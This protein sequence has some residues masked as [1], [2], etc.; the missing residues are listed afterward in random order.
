MN[1]LTDHSHR[2][3]SISFTLMV[4][5]MASIEKLSA[6]ES[7]HRVLVLNS[8]HQGLPWTRGFTDGINKAAEES[9]IHWQLYYE[10]LD[11]TRTSSFNASYYLEYLE[12]RYK[13]LR[14]DGIIAE[15]EPAVEFLVRNKHRIH[16]TS[17]VYYSERD[18]VDSKGYVVGPGQS[19]FTEKTLE[20]AIAQNPGRNQI[21]FIE[22]GIPPRESKEAQLRAK[23]QKFPGY[24][25]TQRKDFFMDDLLEEVTQYPDDT[26]IIYNLVFEDKSGV[27]LAPRKV[28]EKI[29]RAAKVPVYA[30]YSTFLDSGIVGGH[31]SDANTA[32]RSALTALND[33]IQLGQYSD[34]YPVTGT[35][36][37]A[38]VAARYGIETVGL[39]PD[40]RIVNKPKSWW[41]LNISY[42]LWAFVAAILLTFLGL[43]WAA[44]LRVMNNRLTELNNRL[45]EAQQ[46]L[47]ETNID[48]KKQSTIDPLTGL[49]N[50]R[51]MVP[52]LKQ[53]IYECKRYE[54]VSSLLLMDL[55]NF[56][57][58][59]D[60]F[61]HIAGDEV[62]VAVSSILNRE[63]RVSDSLCRWGGEEFLILAK[64]TPQTE[65]EPFAENIRKKI[66]ALQ[67]SFN[68]NVT[69]SIGI[70][71]VRAELT[72][73]ELLEFAD[74][75]M[76]QAKREGKNCIVI[77]SGK[78]G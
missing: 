31:L 13:N 45:L 75:A 40:V 60:E 61:G 48:L 5:L 21:V 42:L 77:Y 11:I 1:Q 63:S 6:E 7:I 51:A 43:L 55:D 37:D 73:N 44:K 29:A 8:Y 35:F 26:M 32:G 36:I 66:A 74:D 65:V 47:E 25:L 19:Q 12:T 18:L 58:I 71:I 24:R 41:L 16:A 27:N 67:F 56:K 15:S 57:S 34:N 14:F 10:N 17:Y 30:F 38:T 78:N 54:T 9:E 46:S 22:S 69:L 62:L 59:N 64:A 72:I 28:V 4:V 49:L 39:G 53:A 20:L 33:F 76:Y 52:M 70:C 50:R 68:A 2:I 23:L 3:A